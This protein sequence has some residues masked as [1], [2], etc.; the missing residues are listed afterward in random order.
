MTAA[1]LDT[2]V[3]V[4]LADP[5][6]SAALPAE[7]A[8]SSITLAELTAGPQLAADPLERARRIAHLQRI[9]GLFDALPFDREAARSYGLVVAAVSRAGRSHRRRFA[10]LLIASVAQASRADLYTRNP[11]DFAGLDDLLTII[12]I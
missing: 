1:L 5:R 3:V 9:E 8:I 12:A 7:A 2:S 6:V 4:D 10:D 11:A